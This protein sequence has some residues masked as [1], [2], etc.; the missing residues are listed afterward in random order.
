MRGLRGHVQTTT[1]SIHALAASAQDETCHNDHSVTRNTTWLR[2]QCLYND[3]GVTGTKLWP[4]PWCDKNYRSVITSSVISTTIVSPEYH[5]VIITTT[6]TRTTILC[7]HQPC[8]DYGKYAIVSQSNSEDCSYRYMLQ[9]PIQ[10]DNNDHSLTRTTILWSQ[11]PHWEHKTTIC[12]YSVTE[13]RGFGYHSLNNTVWSEL[14]HCD[15]S[16]HSVTQ[17]CDQ[18][19]HSD[20]SYHRVKCRTVSDCCDV[21]QLHN[22]W[23]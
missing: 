7:L 4:R 11:P 17:H 13:K 6:V 2:P 5:S 14:P 9:L 18:N 16:N 22:I 3:H 23:H 8:Y 19:G 20:N 15:Y 10:C 1:G 21:N 12:G